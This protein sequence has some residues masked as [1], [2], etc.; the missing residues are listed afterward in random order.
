MHMN[1]DKI[2]FF[3]IILALFFAGIIGSIIRTI[4]SHNVAHD[5]SVVDFSTCVQAGNP[6]M[7]SYPRQCNTQ[8]GQH[9]VEDIEGSSILPN[10][11]SE[12]AASCV[13]AG[14]SG[15]LCVKKEIANEIESGC[16]YLPQ[17]ACYKDALCEQQKTGACGW[18]QTP[19][20]QQCFSDALSESHRANMSF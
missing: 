5:T 4:D 6:I 10:G 1:N 18:T 14:C 19:E 8:A 9:F 17:Y 13:R 2:I 11:N 16:I 20:L 15:E 3:L 7:E 12:P